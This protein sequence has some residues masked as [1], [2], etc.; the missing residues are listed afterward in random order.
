MTTMAK[1]FTTLL[2]RIRAMDGGATE[3]ARP[4]RRGFELALH[5]QTGRRSEERLPAGSRS[6]RNR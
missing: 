6:P 4:P 2:V 1:L 3:R 5:P